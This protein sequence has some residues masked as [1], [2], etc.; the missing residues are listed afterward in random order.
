[1]RIR[2]SW[3]AA[4]DLRVLAVRWPTP[5]SKLAIRVMV[6]IQ[7]RFVAIDFGASAARGWSRAT[8]WL[9]LIP[10]CFSLARNESAVLLGGTSLGFSGGYFHLL[11]VISAPSSDPTASSLFWGSNSADN[12]FR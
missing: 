8:L 5:F 11:S 2:E 4:L 3:A 6:G 10:F 9:C 7:G 12:V 1:M